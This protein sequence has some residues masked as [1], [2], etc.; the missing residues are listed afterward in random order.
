[1][2]AG[3]ITLPR[4]SVH[5]GD[6]KAQHLPAIVQIGHAHHFRFGFQPLE[7]VVGRRNQHTHLV[8][9]LRLALCLDLHAGARQV[10]TQRWNRL[11]AVSQRHLGLQAHANVIAL[12]RV[13]TIILAHQAILIEGRGFC[14]SSYNPRPFKV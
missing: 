1:M 9:D 13:I 11:A 3:S 5:R 14:C 10:P 4:V 12:F 6:G 2:E 7:R 8:A